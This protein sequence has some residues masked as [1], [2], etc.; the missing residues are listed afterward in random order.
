[1]TGL[2]NDHFVIYNETKFARNHAISNEI[3]I[4]D[5]TNKRL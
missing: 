2:L 1:M 4:T 3:H 5:S